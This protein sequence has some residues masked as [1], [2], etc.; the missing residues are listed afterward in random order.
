[1]EHDVEGWNMDV[2][3]SNMYVVGRWSTVLMGGACC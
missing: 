3:G 1:M 2:V